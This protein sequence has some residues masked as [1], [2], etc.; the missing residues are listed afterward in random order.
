MVSASTQQLLPSL[1]PQLSIES[2]LV[3]DLPRPPTPGTQ[4]SLLYLLHPQETYSFPSCSQDSF[5]TLVLLLELATLQKP[6][7]PSPKIKTVVLTN[8]LVFGET[9]SFILVFVWT[10]YSL[11]QSFTYMF[12]CPHHSKPELS[13]CRF[14]N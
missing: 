5:P 3:F 12:S 2:G 11:Q 1:R 4:R 14:K 13:F 9:G 8:L 10:V 6:L 7:V